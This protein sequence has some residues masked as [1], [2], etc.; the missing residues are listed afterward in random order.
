MGRS[1]QLCTCSLLCPDRGS[2]HT[3]FLL[4]SARLCV[5]RCGDRRNPRQDRR[6]HGE[7][8]REAQRQRGVHRSI[9]HPRRLPR[10]SAPLP[11]GVAGRTAEGRQAAGG[12][13]PQGMQSAWIPLGLLLRLLL[14]LLLAGPWAQVAERKQCRLARGLRA[15]IGSVGLC[16]GQ[17]SY[18]ACL[19]LPFY[20]CEDEVLTHSVEW[21]I[22]VL[23]DWVAPHLCTCTIPTP[24]RGREEES[25]MSAKVK[26]GN[27]VK[28]RWGSA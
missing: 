1:F 25:M 4:L 23:Y 3:V 5:L 18:L 2:S 17:L 11:G 12:R 27:P 6:G 14:G 21:K 28:H 26:P 24:A 7:S 22:H 8:A 16:D 13:R 10:A 20:T 15:R 9:V 19:T